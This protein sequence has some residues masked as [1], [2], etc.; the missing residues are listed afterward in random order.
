MLYDFLQADYNGVDLKRVGAAAIG[1]SFAWLGQ[2][3][4]YEE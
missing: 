4:C 2:G 1:E 3:G